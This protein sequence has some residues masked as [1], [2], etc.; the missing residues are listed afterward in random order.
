M[1]NACH[2]G[3][4]FGC[5]DKK[6]PNYE[7]IDGVKHYYIKIGESE[8]G[9]LEVEGDLD[10]SPAGEQVTINIIPEDRYFLNYLILNGER[11]TASVK[12]AGTGH[13][14]FFKDLNG[15]LWCSFHTID[16]PSKSY[17][18][19]NW[20]SRSVLISRVWFKDGIPK[21]EYSR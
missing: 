11:I 10:K 1:F 17:S 18:A 12:S 9:R 7:T 15:K 21:I 3:Y 2:Y 6:N 20:P 14:M 19:S 13:S 8:N 16:D 5:S 4:I